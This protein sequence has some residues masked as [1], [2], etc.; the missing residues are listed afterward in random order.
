MY[1]QVTGFEVRYS[2]QLSYRCKAGSGARTRDS[3]YGKLALYQLSYARKEYT[4][5]GSNL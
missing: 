2:I 1:S 3:E 5:Q 4:R